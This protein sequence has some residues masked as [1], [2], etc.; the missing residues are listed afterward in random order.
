MESDNFDR[1]RILYG[2]AED[3]LYHCF[4]VIKRMDAPVEIVWK[5]GERQEMLRGIV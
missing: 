2:V 5:A 3:L 4:H 1:D